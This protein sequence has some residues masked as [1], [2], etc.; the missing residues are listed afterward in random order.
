MANNYE[1][2][3]AAWQPDQTEGWVASEVKEKNVDGDK[4]TLIFLLENG[5]VR[6]CSCLFAFFGRGGKFW[7][8]ADRNAYQSKTVETTLAEL[9]VPNNPSLP[10]LMNP[11]MLEASEDLTN[12]SHLNEPAG[13]KYE[14]IAK[15]P[16][17]TLLQFSRLSNYDTHR[18]K[19]IHTVVLC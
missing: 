2:G 10:P 16:S 13:K 14:R 11:A 18:K 17:L 15:R 7:K 5:E 4:V 1:V 9:Q 12:L 8:C 3:T 6:D 19:S